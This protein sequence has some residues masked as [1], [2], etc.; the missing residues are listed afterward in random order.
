MRDMAF[1]P[2]TSAVDPPIMDDRA[3]AVALEMKLTPVSF[4]RNVRRN[5]ASGGTESDHDSGL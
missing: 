1:T 5:R 3:V 2:E 4:R